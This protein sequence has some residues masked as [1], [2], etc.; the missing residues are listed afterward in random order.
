LAGLNHSQGRIQS[1]GTSEFDGAAKLGKLI[2][3]RCLELLE[4]AALLGSFGFNSGKLAQAPLN[5]SQGQI[6]WL[7]VFGVVGKQ[8]SSLAGLGIEQSFD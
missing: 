5:P 7:Q 1:H 3:Y 4:T 8:E 2:R 6:V